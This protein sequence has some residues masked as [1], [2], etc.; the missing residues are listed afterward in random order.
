MREQQAPV[1]VLATRQVAGE[2]E[3]IGVQHRGLLNR[4]GLAGASSAGR[5][6]SQA[7]RFPVTIQ[8]RRGDATVTG[9]RA[10][11]P[12]CK[13]MRSRV[14]PVTPWPINASPSASL[15]I[16][17][18]G[19]PRTR[20]TGTVSRHESTEMNAPAGSPTALRPQAGHA[21]AARNCASADTSSTVGRASISTY[22]SATTGPNSAGTPRN[23]NPSDTSFENRLSASR[24]HQSERQMSL[25]RVSGA[26]PRS[27]P[28][29]APG[30]NTTSCASRSRM[31][32]RIACQRTSSSGTEPRCCSSFGRSAFR[33]DG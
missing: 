4:T 23:G 8:S 9:S 2:A 25:R 15:T 19:C 1:T 10:S 13:G 31:D 30:S 33:I 6:W 29:P 24:K 32:S 27:G 5:V 12:Y 26:L 20:P 21:S 16:N 11:T 7:R 18:V 14:I 22:R 3:E 28:N 17:W